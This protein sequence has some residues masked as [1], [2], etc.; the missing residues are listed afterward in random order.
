MTFDNYD[1]TKMTISGDKG[2]NAGTYT[3]TFTPKLGYS[4]ADGSTGAKT[5]SWVIEKKKIPLPTQK[6]TLTYNG[7]PQSPEWDGYDSSIMASSG[8]LSGTNAGVYSARFTLKSNYCWSDG[9]YSTNVD[10]V[11]GRRKI[12]PPKQVGELVYNKKRQS[13]TWDTN[14]NL[15]I[16]EDIGAV[17]AGTY[18]AVFNC[19]NNHYFD[20][21]D[22]DND[23]QSTVYWT[24]KRS[25]TTVPPDILDKEFEYDGEEHY[26]TWEM[27][28]D[29]TE[30][31]TLRGDLSAVDAGDYI[32]EAYPT[33]NYCWGNGSIGR[34]VYQWEITRKPILK[35]PYLKNTTLEYSGEEQTPQWE[36]FPQDFVEGL[37]LSATEVGNYRAIFTVDR[38]HCWTDGTSAPKNI[39]WSIDRKRIEKPSYSGNLVYNGQEQHP[40][41]SYNP[42]WV[43]LTG[44]LNGVHAGEYITVFTPTANYQWKD[45]GYGA[46]SVAWQIDKY[47]YKYPFQAENRNPNN[48]TM[49]NPN[50]S[51]CLVYNGEA[52]S[53]TLWFGNIYNGKL[54]KLDFEKM[55][56]VGKT[57]SAINAGDYFME[58]TPDGDHCWENGNSNP[59]DVPWRIMKR[60]LE[61]PSQDAKGL[62]IPSPRGEQYYTGEVI[63]PEF[64]NYDPDI[65]E[66][67]GQTSAVDVGDYVVYFDIRDKDNYEW[68]DGRTDKVPVTWRIINPPKL[69]GYP[70]QR[71]YLPYNG[72]YQSPEWE[73]YDPK[74]MILVGGTPRKIDV[75][76]YTVEFQLK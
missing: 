56:A 12:S 15:T 43:E 35:D 75:G 22:P 50:V 61:D 55:F 5:V 13:P 25:P 37:G 60:K 44:D 48:P 14:D 40:N 47:H 21:H 36:N 67:S 52:Q 29:N 66:I 27:D 59:Y 71:N 10:W 20:S 39:S 30:R 33:D 53:P 76:D 51:E 28:E 65:L 1:P 24:I 74:A 58:L 54:T 64:N 68:T 18:P 7:N 34:I 16:I 69:V 38:N 45:G 17:D 4:W 3:A 70:Y 32:I 42:S 46:Y 23:Q 41:W 9:S 57:Q 19:D 2:T 72:K 63:Y 6:G 49:Y 73:L 26:P 62:I 8:V 11:I 31:M